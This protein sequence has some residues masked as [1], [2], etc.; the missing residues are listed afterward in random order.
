M[1]GKMSIIISLDQCD[2]PSTK[3]ILN[4]I[5][6]GGLPQGGGTWEIINE[7]KP[8]DLYCYLYVKY[9]PPNGIQSALR[10]DDSDN[11][12]HWDWTF[13]HDLG[14][15]TILGLNLRTEVHLSGD[16]D[17]SHCDRAAF[18]HIIKSDFC[19]YGKEMS[20]FRRKKLEHWDVFIN[21][22]RQLRD[23][24]DL[25]KA[26]LD[27]INLE[28]Q[29]EKLDNPLTSADFL[30]YK[31]EWDKMMVRY[32]KG[33]GLAMSLKI[34][35]PI[36]AESFIQLV[37]VFLCR[38]EI[39]TNKR[40]F[41]NFLR[42]NIDIRVQSLHI[43]CIGF[44]TPVDWRADQCKEYNNIVNQRN[45][46]L[47]GNIDIEKLKFSEIF[48]NKTVPV[49]NEYMTMWQQSLGVA[50]EHSG[51]GDVVKWYDIIE[52]FTKYVIS[53]ME[54]KIQEQFKIFMDKRDIGINRE[55]QRLGI[56]LPDHLADF[57]CSFL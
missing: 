5:H 48:F 7:I 4:I 25:F 24:V 47:H 44:L 21:P 18:I 1:R 10:N 55:N 51:I 54:P 11:L 26:E 27:D 17:F 9:G 30:K 45:D 8:S 40:L 31:D 52:D 43:N 49:F 19:N 33:M 29:K 14:L 38:P 2:I 56:L 12:I 41:D 36:L 39:K 32:T 37:I 20:E 22:Y 50:V 57:R 34:M 35:L 23:T 53:C 42:D 46:L 15:I 6:G 3:C 13:A 16:F 28:P